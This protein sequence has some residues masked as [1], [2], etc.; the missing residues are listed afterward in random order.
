MIRTFRLPNGIQPHGNCS[1]ARRSWHLSVVRIFWA[2][3]AVA[4]SCTIC[5]F[6]MADA[7]AKAKPTV[8]AWLVGPLHARARKHRGFE[9]SSP[10]RSP[11]I[12]LLPAPPRQKQ[13]GAKR[14]RRK[15]PPRNS[16]NPASCTPPGAASGMTASDTWPLR[17]RCPKCGP[18]WLSL[19]FEIALPI[20]H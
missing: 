7:K 11:R 13:M 3:A 5:T 1:V 6:G 8:L 9:R 18:E 20:M 16:R 19:P 17:L 2:R 12:S 15:S 14:S 4:Y 10:A